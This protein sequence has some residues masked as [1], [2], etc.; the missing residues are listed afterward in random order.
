MKLPSNTSESSG[1]DGWILGTYKRERNERGK[2]FFSMLHFLQT[3][4]F[5]II[6]NYLLKSTY[7]LDS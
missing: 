3:N 5:Q 7:S 6:S 1:T 2:V 4:I